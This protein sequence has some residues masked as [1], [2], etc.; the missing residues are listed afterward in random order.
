M[1]A[2]RHW[3]QELLPECDARDVVSLIASELTANA[4]RHTASGQPGGWFG[5]TVTWAAESVLVEVEDNGGPLVPV[6][7]EDAD[8][9]DGR[10]LQVVVHL[11]D[12]VTVR[13]DAKGRF[14]CAV[15][16]W[17]LNGGPPPH[18]LGHGIDTAPALA[19]LQRAI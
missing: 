4:V 5:V 11:S 9:E 7:V 12:A 19:S 13:G 2:A 8:G 6:V 3:V 17:A 10:G 14:V 16:P 1:R 15:I 18:A